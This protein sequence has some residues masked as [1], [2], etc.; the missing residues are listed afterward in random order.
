MPIPYLNVTISAAANSEAYWAAA[1][2]LLKQ[3][4]SLVN[5]GVFGY[6][7]T[8][9]SFPISSSSFAA[10]Y[11]GYF[12]AP[13]KPLSVLVGALTPLFE[14]INA[15]WPGQF[16]ILFD[17]YSYPDFY[18]WWIS[19]FPSSDFGVGLDGLVANRFLD[20][21]A[22]SAPQETWVQALKEITPPGAYVDINVI[23]GPGVWHAVPSGGSDSIHPGWRKAYVEFGKFPP[24]FFIDLFP[25]LHGRSLCWSPLVHHVPPHPHKDDGRLTWHSKISYP[26]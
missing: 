6:V 3:Y 26:I 23:A 16:T 18:S 10:S 24:P 8:G 21:N 12:L 1:A 4:P 14:H 2:Y 7:I 19:A 11:I 13:N 17:T 5:S 15:T 9:G 25:V 22:L 20:A